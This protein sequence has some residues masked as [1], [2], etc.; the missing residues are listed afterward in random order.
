MSSNSIP[1]TKLPFVTILSNSIK[2]L[3]ELISLISAAF[4]LIIA[5]VLG[6]I[7]NPNLDANCTALNILSGSSEKDFSPITRMTLFF[8]SSI[9]LKGSII[10]PSCPFAIALIVKSLL[11]SSLSTGRLWSGENSN[12]VCPADFLFSVLGIAISIS[13]LEPLGTNLITP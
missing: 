13:S 5:S 9:P 6:S 3:S 8:K 1:V 12:P 4:S 7:L 2:N 11:P 10:F